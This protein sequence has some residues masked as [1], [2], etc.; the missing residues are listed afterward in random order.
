[1]VSPLCAS[2]YSLTWLNGLCK[3]SGHA[4]TFLTLLVRST[5]HGRAR[6]EGGNIVAAGNKM[7]ASDILVRGN[8]RSVLQAVFFFSSSPEAC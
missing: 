5:G 6:L 7:T 8:A 2:E 3:L 4:D 1:M